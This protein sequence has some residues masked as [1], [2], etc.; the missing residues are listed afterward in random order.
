MMADETGGACDEDFHRSN[1]LTI[2]NCCAA[3]SILGIRY[4]N[5]ANNANLHYNRIDKLWRLRWPH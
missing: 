4:A 1:L 2:L 5:S 3:S